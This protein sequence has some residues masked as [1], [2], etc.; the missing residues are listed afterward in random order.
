MRTK[1]SSLGSVGLLRSIWSVSS[2]CGAV[3]VQV[4]VMTQTVGM[5]RQHLLPDAADS[6]PLELWAGLNVDFTEI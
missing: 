6:E 2:Y 5:L 3:G 4:L 1:A